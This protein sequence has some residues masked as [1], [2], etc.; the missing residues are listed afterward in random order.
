MKYEDE[1]KYFLG[2]TEYLPL[3]HETLDS[4]SC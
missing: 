2:Y 1:K 4:N 3:T